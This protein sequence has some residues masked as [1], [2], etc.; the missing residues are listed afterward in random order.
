MPRNGKPY[1]DPATRMDT[2]AATRKGESRASILDGKQFVVWDGEGARQPGKRKPQN[3]VLFGCYDGTD[4]SWITGEQLNTHECLSFIIAQGRKHRGA[5][6]VAFAFDY[7]VNMILRNLSPKQFAYLRDHGHT[8]VGD[9]YRVEHIPGK[10]FRVT[11]YGPQFPKVRKDRY[12]VTIFDTWGFFQS[13]LLAALQNYLGE[14]PEGFDLVKEGKARREGFTY[15]EL[16]FI[17][18]YWRVENELA[19]QMVNKLRDYL[20]AAGLRIAKWHGPGALASYA[21]RT[22]KVGPHKSDCG[23]RI[24]TAARYA[25][26]G[27]RF[28]R[29]HI[30]R[31]RNAYSYDL[32][33]A[34]PHA[35][36]QLPSLSEGQWIHV[37]KPTDRLAEFGVYRVSLRGPA[38]SRKPGPLFHRDQRGNISF[39]WRTD[40]WYWSPEL[41]AM[42][43]NLPRGVELSVHEGYEYVGWHTRPFEFVREVYDQRRIMKANGDGAQVALKLLL[44]SLYGKMAQRAGWERTGKAPT[45][46][47]LEW[48]GW[49]TS[50]TRA[51]LFTLMTKIPYDKLI[52]VETDGLFTT[53]TPSELGIVD[54]KELGGWEITEHAELIYL[55][56][57]LYTKRAADD[58]WLLKYRGLDSDSVSADRIVEH[59][60]SL[61]GTPWETLDGTTTRFI[62]YRNALFRETQNRGPFHVHFRVWETE[63]KEIDCGSV[64]KRVH[65]PKMCAACKAG[66]NAYEM[67]HETVIK[68]ATA[69]DN[70]CH[71]HMHAIPWIDPESLPPFSWL[72]EDQTSDGL[73]RLD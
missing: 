25:Y 62:G 44:N 59:A 6:H 47:Q 48:A 23:E 5:W 70:D 46:H 26:A 3:Y 49:V 17:T 66:C 10:W 57:G 36:A 67:P 43:G 16:E 69:I 20:Y 71:S 73:V 33:S 11:E 64:G 14:N 35:I 7:D 68:S 40:G 15:G 65:S 52:A 29:F 55:Q 9:N 4:H 31:Y 34:Y 21:Y 50:H 38:I 58:V 45:W 8:K 41:R 37:T 22:R 24:Y 60:R 42:Q 28:E 12:S 2:D 72:V 51:A 1:A 18:K 61:S 27:G 30:G 39:P 56:S 19:W 32:N 63:H 54:S 53:C 13:S